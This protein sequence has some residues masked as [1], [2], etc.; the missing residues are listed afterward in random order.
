MCGMTTPPA[1]TLELQGGRWG[2]RMGDGE[3]R[4]ESGRWENGDK[5]GEWE[6]GR[7]MGR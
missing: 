3:M 5:E 4:R 1:T 6:M 7:E 2:G